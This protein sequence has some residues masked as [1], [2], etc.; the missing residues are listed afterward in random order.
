MLLSRH[1]RRFSATR[2]A[3]ASPI[4]GDIYT[5]SSLLFWSASL[6]QYLSCHRLLPRHMRGV[7]KTSHT[8]AP[9]VVNFARSSRLSHSKNA[10]MIQQIPAQSSA[11][12][13]SAASGHRFHLLFA[14]QD[15]QSAPYCLVMGTFGVRQCVICHTPRS[16]TENGSCLGASYH[17]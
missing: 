17:S 16:P 1:E 9:F 5:G 8:R 12:R 6:K 10:A 13:R 11:F 4:R 15:R 7:E 14:C 3:A 2:P